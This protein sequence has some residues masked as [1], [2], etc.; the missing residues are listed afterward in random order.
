MSKVKVIV[1]VAIAA[2]FS[3]LAISSLY[4]DAKIAKE[5]GKTCTHC[6]VKVGK[7]ELNDV[8]KCYKEKKKSLDECS[9]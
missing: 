7:P 1:V 2:A 4:A 9:K 5:T 8:G 6:H 3:V